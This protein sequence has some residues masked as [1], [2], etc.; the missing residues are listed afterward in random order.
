MYFA[1]FDILHPYKGPLSTDEFVC[2]N[3]GRL[4]RHN[5]H[6]WHTEN[7]KWLRQA[8]H[9]RPQ[10]VNIRYGTFGDRIIRPFFID[11]TSSDEQCV[12]FLSYQRVDLLENSCTP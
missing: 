4:N 8:V 5:M 7:P 9:Q 12:S 2:I 3:H 6:Y 11:A 1:Y 10:S